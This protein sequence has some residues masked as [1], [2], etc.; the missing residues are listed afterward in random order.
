MSQCV[1]QSDDVVSKSNATEQ[2]FKVA[3]AQLKRVGC[4]NATGDALAAMYAQLAQS[5]LA[6]SRKTQLAIFNHLRSHA[7]MLGLEIKRILREPMA[8]FEII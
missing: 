7:D 8:I 1:S 3:R 2:L 4:A 6:L 5:T